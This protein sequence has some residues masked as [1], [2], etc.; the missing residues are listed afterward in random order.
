MVENTKI[1]KD[2]TEKDTK[3]NI[4]TNNNFDVLAEPTVEASQVDQEVLAKNEKSVEIKPPKIDCDNYRV[5]FKD[6][7]ENFRENPS[8]SPKYKLVATQMMHNSFNMFHMD[9]KD[10]EKF[11]PSLGLFV[12]VQHRKLRSEITT[13]IQ[14]FIGELDLGDLKHGLYFHIKGTR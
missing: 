12:V 1:R 11:N 3:Y 10:I 5:V 14:N 13:L 9:L 2:F 6:F 4:E 8:E 7:L